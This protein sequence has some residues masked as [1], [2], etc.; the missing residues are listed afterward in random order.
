[1]Q[2]AALFWAWIMC[3]AIL[4]LVVPDGTL[5][6]LATVATQVSDWYSALDPQ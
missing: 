1:M 5:G 6:S 3:I 4:W 2:I